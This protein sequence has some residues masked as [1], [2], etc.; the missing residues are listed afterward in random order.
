MYYLWFKTNKRKKTKV[1]VLF[2][3]KQKR[4][5]PVLNVSPLILFEQASTKESIF[6]KLV[7]S[8]KRKVS[9]SNPWSFSR[10]TWEPIPCLFWRLSFCSRL[11]WEPNSLPLF[12]RLSFH[13]TCEREIRIPCLFFRGFLFISR[14]NVT[15]EFLLLSGALILSSIASQCLCSICALRSD[16]PSKNRWP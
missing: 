11:T 9:G 3:S 2:K 1:C 16:K 13:F 14:A 15:A 10:Q 5:S 6:R 4:R 12:W 7:E 8:S